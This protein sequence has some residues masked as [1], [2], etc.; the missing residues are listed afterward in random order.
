MRGKKEG[1]MG[2][3]RID[4]GVKQKVREAHKAGHS[5]KEIAK[6]FGISPTSVSRIV[7]GAGVQKVRKQP[8]EKTQS[9]D[10]AERDKKIQEVE[11]RIL[12]LE[13]KILYWHSK[14]RG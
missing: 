11:R 3:K 9:P 2:G 4:E 13:A 7:K 5:R 6:K 12:E 14:K 10:H 8:T 1:A